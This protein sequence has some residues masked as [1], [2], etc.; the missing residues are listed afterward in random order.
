MSGWEWR[1]HRRMRTKRR[2]RI[3]NLRR[4]MLLRKGLMEPG[5]TPSEIQFPF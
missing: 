1:R 4:N 3:D 5:M 2:H